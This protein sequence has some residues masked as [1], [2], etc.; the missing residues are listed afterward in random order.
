MNSKGSL[1]R[2]YARSDMGNEGSNEDILPTL[3]LG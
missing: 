2:R 3:V 1:G